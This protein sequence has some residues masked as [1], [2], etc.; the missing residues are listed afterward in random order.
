M[1]GL[2]R[3]ALALLLVAVLGVGLAGAEVR[4]LGSASLA[5][6]AS[7]TTSAI[8][9]TDT[10]ATSVVL[11]F[12]NGTGVAGNVTVKLQGAMDA[13]NW[14]DIGTAEQVPATVAS[15]YYLVPRCLM[16]TA[17]GDNT[18]SGPVVPAPH[19]RLVVTNNT[20]ATITVL[21]AAFIHYQ[22]R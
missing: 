4:L 10:E 13:T 11:G 9:W 6:G 2:M 20:G 8:N 22:S 12:R 3:G 1:R 7:W 18:K 15:T 17:L 16:A 19:L 14:V 21:K 5:N